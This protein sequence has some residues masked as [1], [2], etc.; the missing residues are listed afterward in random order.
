MKKAAK[1]TY[2]MNIYGNVVGYVGG[3]R[4]VEFGCQPHA[5]LWGQKW[6]EG[7]NYEAAETAALD[8]RTSGMVFVRGSA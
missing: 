5:E 3:R 7:L 4:F 2:K 8:E 6:A 1:R